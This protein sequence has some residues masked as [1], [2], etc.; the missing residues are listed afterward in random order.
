MKK[1]ILTIGLFVAIATNSFAQKGQQKSSEERAQ[2]STEMMEKNLSLTA[3][4]KTK[5]YAAALERAKAMEALRTEA[6]EGNQPDKEKMKAIS[7]K[8]NKVLK[9]TLNDEQKAKM[10]EMKANRPKPEGDSTPKKE[11]NDS[12]K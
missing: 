1:Y 4:Q 7:M 11:S 8:Y 6:G 12:Q 10:E 2:K 5:I 3:D 9:E